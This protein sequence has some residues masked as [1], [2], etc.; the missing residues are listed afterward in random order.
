MSGLLLCFVVV[1]GLVMI[2]WNSLI[3]SFWMLCW[4]ERWEVNEDEVT[5][6]VVCVMSVCEDVVSFWL[7]FCFC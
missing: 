4:G 1:V 7:L 2:L 5:E 6:F 3:F